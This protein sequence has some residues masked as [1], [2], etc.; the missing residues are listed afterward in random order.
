MLPLKWFQGEI[1]EARLGEK[2]QKK[3]QKAKTKEFLKVQAFPRKH[4]YSFRW[5]FPQFL[6]T[7]QYPMVKNW[8]AL[9]DRGKLAGI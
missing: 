5:S 6:E 9:N 7:P 1:K 3:H 2:T 8:T 4:K